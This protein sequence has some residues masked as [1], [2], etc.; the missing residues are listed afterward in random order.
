VLR[1]T[2]LRHH[3]PSTCFLTP[4]GSI[5]LGILLR[6]TYCCTHHTFHLGF[7]TDACCTRVTVLGGLDPSSLNCFGSSFRDSLMWCQ[8]LGTHLPPIPSL[9]KSS[10]IRCKKRA[11]GFKGGE[12]VSTPTRKCCCM[13]P[14]S[15]FSIS[16]W[17]KMRGNFPRGG[18]VSCSLKK[19]SDR[20][21]RR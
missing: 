10:T 14:S 11:N 12:G 8:G 20:S 16:T 1:R 17:H 18:G 15:S 6:E 3:Q 4:T 5:N 13:R 19:E 2:T 21:C 9:V 7:P